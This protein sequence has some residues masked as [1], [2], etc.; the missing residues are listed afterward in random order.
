MTSQSSVSAAMWLFGFE[1]WPANWSVGHPHTSARGQCHTRAWYYPRFT[2]RTSTCQRHTCACH[3]PRFTPRTS[4][5]GQC[6]TC[7]CHYP[8]V[9]TPHQHMP[10]SHV[11][12]PPYKGSHPAPAQASVTR[13]HATMQRFTPRSYSPTVENWL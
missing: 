8:Q 4:A 6:H 5:R 2:P 9:H 3:Y 1:K 11:R 13:A 10:A 12:M 7:A